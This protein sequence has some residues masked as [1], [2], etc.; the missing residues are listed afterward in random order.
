M[1]EWV[2]DYA[3]QLQQEREQSGLL[4]NVTSDL[5]SAEQKLAEVRERRK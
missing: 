2:K 1:T 3:K 5:I 4:P